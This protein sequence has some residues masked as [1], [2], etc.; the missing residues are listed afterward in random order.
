VGRLPIQVTPHV[1]T[2][3][4]AACAIALAQAG[5]SVCLI[6]RHPPDDIPPNL[7]TLNA[8]RA[9]GATAHVIHCNLDDLQ[10]VK[11][12]FQKALDVMNGQIHVLVNCAGIQRRSP[13]VDFSE[14]DWDQ[15]RYPRSLWASVTFIMTHRDN[16]HFFP[17]FARLGHQH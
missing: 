9:L 2:G 13:S 16:S 5:A 12:I 4:G 14:N 17:A 10:A 8:I 11:H 6:Q 1:C 3:I 15:V 7:E